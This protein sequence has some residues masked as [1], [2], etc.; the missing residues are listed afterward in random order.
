MLEHLYNLAVQVTIGESHCICL[1]K[2]MLLNDNV[3]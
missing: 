1:A 3:V 2:L